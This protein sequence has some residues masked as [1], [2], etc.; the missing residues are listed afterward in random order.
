MYT[1]SRTFLTPDMDFRPAMKAAH[2]DQLLPPKKLASTPQVTPEKAPEYVSPFASKVNELSEKKRARAIFKRSSVEGELENERMR[3]TYLNLLAFKN[4]DH[5]RVDEECDV[6]GSADVGAVRGKKEGERGKQNKERP[7]NTAP[8]GLHPAFR[9]PLRPPAKLTVSAPTVPT[10]PR[11]VHDSTL[12]TSPIGNAWS[13][14][15]YWA[16]QFSPSISTAPSPGEKPSQCPAI[17]GCHLSKAAY[18]TVSDEV[19]ALSRRIAGEAALAGE[20]LEEYEADALAAEQVL[21]LKNAELTQDYGYPDTAEISSRIF[22]LAIEERQARQSFT[23]KSKEELRD[24]DKW[25][26]IDEE[27]FK[28]STI[29]DHAK[30]NLR[31]MKERRKSHHLDLSTPAYSVLFALQVLEEKQERLRRSQSESESDDE[32]QYGH[33]LKSIQEEL[34]VDQHKRSSSRTLYSTDTDSLGWKKN[35]RFKDST[36]STMSGKSTLVEE[37][38]KELK[39]DQKSPAEA[40]SMRRNAALGR[41]VLEERRMKGKA[42]SALDLA[43]WAT[44][45]KRMEEEGK[46]KGQEGDIGPTNPTQF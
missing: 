19:D 29:L 20:A 34:A 44:E 18:E 38:R 4:K 37:E 45:L 21:E 12:P 11:S 46:G 15:H 2:S 17:A 16:P 9:A 14:E 23:I 10:V 22:Q 13:G 42:P 43:S 25:L 39:T 24:I 1:L 36:T 41:D 8:E 27:T 26:H 40:R 6:E 5:L 3:T 31:M 7:R 35:A 30:E 33:F 32:F 28:F